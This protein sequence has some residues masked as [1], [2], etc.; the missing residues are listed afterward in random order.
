MLGTLQNSLGCDFAAF[1]NE[2]E[3]LQYLL[4]LAHNAICFHLVATEAL[5]H[6]GLQ[7]LMLPKLQYKLVVF[8]SNWIVI[9]QYLGSQKPGLFL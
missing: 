7:S 6:D 3:L 1:L 4:K 2:V 9:V 8:L 5:I